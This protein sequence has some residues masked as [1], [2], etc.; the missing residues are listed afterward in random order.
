MSDHRISYLLIVFSTIHSYIPII[1][2]KY[3]NDYSPPAR[4][5]T[6]SE[7]SQAIAHTYEELFGLGDIVV[8]GVL[9][10]RRSWIFTIPYLLSVA[11]R[12]L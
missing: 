1:A 12:E 5:R 9:K 4:N 10:L 11:K 3:P 7:R 8:M 6:E 2:S